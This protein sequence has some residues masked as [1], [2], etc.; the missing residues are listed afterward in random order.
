MAD[1]ISYDSDDYTAEYE[2]PTELP[3]DPIG[4]L[5]RWLDEAAAAKDKPNPN[6]MALATVDGDGRPSVR[7]VLCKK[8]VSDPGYIVFFTNYNSRKGRELDARPVASAVFHW[9]TMERQVR[10]EGTVVRSPG[11]ES[12]AYFE[13][14]RVDRR[15]GAWA[16]DQSE[17]IESRDAMLER[18]AETLMK[19]GVV[20]DDGP[21]APIPRPPHWGGYRLVVS[22]IELWI[23]GPGR[24]HDRARWTR[25]V[26]VS[27]DGVIDASPW[28]S[29]RLQP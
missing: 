24:I 18:V 12:D 16:S 29:T 13:S 15:V 23:G 7:I 28:S 10:V 9:D 20:S 4:E 27:A 17:P 22:A 8:I 11:D 25:S 2:L 3:A 21:T 26:E 1:V 14:R 6:S 19:F 5:Q